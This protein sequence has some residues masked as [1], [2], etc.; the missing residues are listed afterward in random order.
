ME[1]SPPARLRPLPRRA[2]ALATLAL[3]AALAAAAPALSYVRPVARP[4]R[5]VTCPHAFALPTPATLPQARMAVACLINNERRRRRLLLLRANAFAGNAAALHSQDMVDRH[6]FEHVT[7]EG[8]TPAMRLLSAR[9]I[10]RSM[11]WYVAE[12]LAWGESGRGTPA[13]VVRSW[14]LSPAHR[15]N[16]LR[17][18]YREFGVAVVTG[19]PPGST[20]YLGA[21]YTVD[22]GARG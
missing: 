12:N 7:P 17:P 14:M 3:V 19:T 4:V 21:T 6:Y 1:C 5:L 15:A 22:F 13:A 9:Y 8:V 10:T 2:L 18:M 11:R 16:I 20:T